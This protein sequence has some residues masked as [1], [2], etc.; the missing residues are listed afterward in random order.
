MWFVVVIRLSRK[1]IVAVAKRFHLE[2]ATFVRRTVLMKEK[3]I[4]RI[5]MDFEV[6]KLRSTSKY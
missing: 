4:E 2:L 5:M 6:E 1:E 3:W